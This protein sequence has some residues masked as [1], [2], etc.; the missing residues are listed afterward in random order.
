[1]KS[2]KFPHSIQLKQARYYFD[3]NAT[4]PIHSDLK[5]KMPELL[6][7]WGNPSSIH[8]AGRQPKH[9]IREART[10]IAKSIGAH[11][12][13]VVF[14][15]GGS[16]ANNTVIKGVYELNKMAGSDR[17]HFICSRLEHPSVIKTM[18]YLAS[19]GAQVDY[20]GVNRK[21]EIDIEEY[22]S[23]LSM[24]TALVSIMYANNETGTLF[25]IAKL[26]QLAH[27]KG[28]LFHTDAV[29]A[30]GKVS[31]NL[32]ELGVDFASFS[33]HKFY[34]LKGTG[35]LFTKK[36]TKLIQ[37]IHGGAQERHRRGGT[38]NTLGI[39]CLGEMAQKIHEVPMK[40]LSVASLRD[41]FETRVLNEIS[42][43]SITAKETLRLPNTSS[44]VLTGCDG[45]TLLMSLDMKGFA[46]STGAACSSGNPEP[47]PVLLAIGL[48]RVEAQNS[49]RISLGWENT[50][51]QVDRLVDQLKEIVDRLRTIKESY[52]EECHV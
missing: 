35:V 34:S 51:E 42:N 29:Q 22:I 46:V 39:A 28:A 15:S 13:E 33:A 43:V 19:L 12:L 44:L 49:L 17:N 52:E 7:A 9:L 32:F 36:G 24:K 40:A 26:C 5:M 48:S 16:E 3:H 1:M 11:P 23:K 38:E 10:A 25:P 6:E 2:E 50:L 47:S 18:Q 45:E 37:L 14:T 21:G 20:I 30:Y 8:W 4:T 27:E 41:H 31:L